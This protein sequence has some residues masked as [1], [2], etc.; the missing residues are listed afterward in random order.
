MAVAESNIDLET[1]DLV[2]INELCRRRLGRK[3][4]PATLWRWRLKGIKGCRL[5]CV[6]VAGNWCS[7]TAAFAAF[8]RQTTEA[9]AT[10][11]HD[12][13]PAERSAATTRRL[14]TA[15]LIT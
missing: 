1:D 13:Q 10:P 4:S 6:Y 5:E 12:A 8:I 2:P 14:K 11:A 3:V 15:G 7:T 9:A